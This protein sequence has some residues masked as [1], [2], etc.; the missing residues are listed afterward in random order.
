[1]IEP[2][3]HLG[4]YEIVASIGSGG[5]GEVFR[6]RDSR[7][8]REVAIK[9]LPPGLEEDEERRQRFEREARTISQLNHP[10]ICTLYDIGLEDGQHYLVMELLEGESL[11]DHLQRGPLPLSQALR[12]GTQVAEA[13]HAAHRQGITHRDLKP[14]NVMLTKSGAKLLDFGL[15]RAET[16]A[17]PASSATSL[18][19]EARPLTEKGTILGTFQYMAPEQLEGLP[20]DAR[21]DIFAFGALLF[22]MVTAKKAFEGKNRTSL[23]AAIVSS[24]PPPVSSVT[25]VSPPALDHVVHK[26]LEKDPDDRWQSAHD[27]AGQL[28]WIGEAGSQGGQAAVSPARRARRPGAAALVAGL[29]G[30]LL[31]AAAVLFFRA[32]DPAAAE[33]PPL[34]FVVEN[35]DMQDSRPRLSP[36]AG[37]IAY[38]KADAL[39]V[40][41]LSRLEPVRVAGTEGARVPFWSPDGEWL[42]FSADGMLWKVRVDGSEKTVLCSQEAPGVNAGGAAWL[43]DG[44]IVFNTG[45]SPLL[46]VSDRGGDARVLLDTSEDE[47]DFHFVSALPDGKGFLFV[48]HE[49]DAFGN[50]TV[51]T[52]NERKT[53]LRH[54]GESI[55][56]PLY[57]PSGHL[58][59]RRYMGR[60]A[61][62]WAVPFSLDRLEVLGEPFPVAPGGAQPTVAEDGT[63][64]YVPIVPR[65]LSRIVRIDRSGRVVQT[66]GEPRV[67]L[68]P[69][70][71]LSPDARRVVLPVAG[72]AGYDLWI[73]DLQGGEPT[74]LT[75]LEGKVASPA[76]TPDGEEVIFAWATTTADTTLRATRVDGSRAVRDVAHGAWAVAFSADGNNLLYNQVGEGFNLNLWHKAFGEDGPGEPLLTDEGWE[77]H[78]ALSPDGRFL[79]YEKDDAVLIRT[80]PDM[81]G[82]WQ[83]AAGGAAVPRWAPR[84]DRLFYLL[85]DDLMEV[86][87]ATRPAVKVGTPRMLFTFAHGPVGDDGTPLFAVTPDGESFIMVEA[88]EPIPGIV[89]A[90]NWLASVE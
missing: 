18:P 6:A 84:G 80:Y 5:M 26:C 3:K 35:G 8:E 30:A 9:V 12:Y 16:E 41:T 64:G 46:E 69:S 17:A 7:L 24:Q 48:V 21:T 2:G 81:G 4:P 88:L 90:Q 52:G 49:G 15:A 39:W 36:D 51:W 60:G 37:R 31:G 78:P 55:Q 14:G 59:Y 89:V 20:A 43:P 50:I 75:F 63:L 67:G 87:V 33:R 54:P 11:A 10:H 65:V 19:T 44:R 68:Y 74:R 23:I 42:G 72:A 82:P 1:M 71:A 25:S 27:V 70:P 86:D 77:I 85:G 83:V 45:R 28:R 79:A 76:W 13:L 66:I 56:N 62:V 53:L 61:A 34:R 57:A 73:Y 38:R 40:R 47:V 22:E 58:V 32:S 29:A